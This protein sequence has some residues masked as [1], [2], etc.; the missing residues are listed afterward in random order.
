MSFL[1]ICK[2]LLELDPAIR[3]ASIV[4][5]DGTLV[6]T[7]TNPNVTLL[8]NREE[9]Q[10]IVM[11]SLI[12]L[13]ISRTMEHKLG[14]PTYSLTKYERM[15]G[16]TLPVIDTGNKLNLGEE[17]VVLLSFDI[18]ANPVLIIEAKVFP[19][20]DKLLLPEIVQAV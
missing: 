2:Q 9:F 1:G 11:Q 19:Y 7:A 17:F 4:Q 15:I 3:T 18:G 10:L 6:A 12:R 8:L 20:I 16:S 5:L 14:K 13:N